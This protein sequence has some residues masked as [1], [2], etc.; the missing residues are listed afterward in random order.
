MTVP[1]NSPA[2]WNSWVANNVVI[3]QRSNSI[4]LSATVVHG[5]DTGRT[6][7]FV[8]HDHQPA[9]IQQASPP[10]TLSCSAGSCLCTLPVHRQTTG[11]ML[12]VQPRPARR[13]PPPP[14]PPTGP[15]CFRCHHLGHTQQNAISTSCR[16]VGVRKSH[17]FTATG[18]ERL[19]LLLPLLDCLAT[20]LRWDR[21]CHR[22]LESRD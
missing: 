7:I 1:S 9:G 22:R 2:H 15:V 18:R 20:A 21:L 12:P 5:F 13:A 17:S 6:S 14:P 11:S 16:H 10:A 4:Q 19:D 8:K 3:T